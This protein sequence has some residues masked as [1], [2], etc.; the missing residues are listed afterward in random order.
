MRLGNFAF[1]LGLLPVGGFADPGINLKEHVL[2]AR[3]GE[4]NLCH[5]TKSA[6][7]ISKKKQTRLEHSQVEAKHGRKTL[8]CNF[9][10]DKNNHNFLNSTPKFPASFAN[11]SPVCQRCHSE[12]FRDWKRGIHGKRT[13]GWQGSE[14]QQFHCIECHNA[15]SVKFKDMVAK[16]APVRPKLGIQKTPGSAE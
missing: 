7:F 12:I 15:H 3:A 11:P 6:K 16:P 9:C 13:G 14:R 1:W 5:M 4:C 10:H 2:P 8:E